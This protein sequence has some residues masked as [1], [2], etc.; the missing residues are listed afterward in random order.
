[1]A[2]RKSK[3]ETLSSDCR[4]GNISEDGVGCK[5][6]TQ[7]YHEQRAMYRPYDEPINRPK[8]TRKIIVRLCSNI[9]ERVRN[10]KVK[11]EWQVNIQKVLV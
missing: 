7:S 11:N 6:I 2:L 3:S 4:L 5:G 1:M 9:R 8:E 10:A